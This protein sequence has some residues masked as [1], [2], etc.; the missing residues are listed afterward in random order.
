MKSAVIDVNKFKTR[1]KIFKKAQ[2]MDELPAPVFSIGRDFRVN[3]INPSGAMFIGKPV[4]EIIGKY[5]FDLCKTKHCKTSD[6]RCRMAMEQG[7]EFSGDIVANVARGAVPVHYTAV[8]IRSGGRIVGAMTMIAENTS[9][10]TQSFIQVPKPIIAIDKDYRIIHYNHSFT[11]IIDVPADQIIGKKCYEILQTEHCGT[12]ECRCAMSMEQ[13]DVFTGDTVA[14]LI[15]GK[16]PVRYTSSPLKNNK[17]EIVGEVNLIVET[18]QENKAVGG[19][20][21]LMDAAIRGNIEARADIDQF[22]GNFRKIIKGVNDTL[23]TVT[24][25]IKIAVESAD[26]LASSS[27]HLAEAAEQSG[28]ATNQIASVCQQVAKSSEDQNRGIESVKSAL[29]ELAEAINTVAKGCLEQDEELNSANKLVDSVSEASRRTVTNAEKA[30][31]ETEQATDVAKRGTAIVEETKEITNLVSAVQNGVGEAIKAS[32][33]GAKRAEN[34]S[35]LA[36]ESGTALTQIIDSFDG[37]TSRIKEMSSASNEMNES[38]GEMVR[39]M[40]NVKRLAEST[41]SAARDMETSKAKVSDATD[42]V[43][44]NIESNSAAMEEMSASAEEM[45]AQVQQVVDSSQMLSDMAQSLETAVSIFSMK[46]REEETDSV[47][48]TIKDIEEDLENRF[49]YKAG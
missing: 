39:I 30:T 19:I 49:V 35:N 18:I 20:M 11:K 2:C 48:E 25:P 22:E 31:I 23:D 28:S 5:C 41:S 8:P 3:Y 37:M 44:D 32:E 6:C 13:D 34:G 24:G 21:S 42:M 12:G 17:G 43:A 15:L 36:N 29:S 14:N 40:G 4:N 1:G 7:Q 47:S 38:S 26:T 46:N 9:T 33:E 45:S 16:C 27:K 10:L